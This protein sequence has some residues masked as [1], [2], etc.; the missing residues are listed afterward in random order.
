MYFESS[1]KGNTENGSLVEL[2]SLSYFKLSITLN[3]LSVIIFI[4]KSKSS[5]ILIHW[6]IT[7]EKKHNS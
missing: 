3:Q 1:F 5:L 6:R 4:I 7:I 2:D